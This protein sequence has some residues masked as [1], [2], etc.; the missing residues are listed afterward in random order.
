MD[1]ANQ[2]DLVIRKATASDAETILA[3]IRMIGD[4]LGTP[5]KISATAEDFRRHGFGPSPAFEVLI[6]EIAGAFAGLCLYF[7]SFSTWRGKPGAYIQ[8]LV[9]DKAFRGS[10]VAEALLRQTARHVRDK[11]GVYLRLSVDAS[12]LTAQRFYERIG[13][14]HQ[15]EEHIHAIYG[16]AFD[17]LA[18]LDESGV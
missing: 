4:H 17:A 9:V 2:N 7:R 18:G 13:L 1:A 12:N 14:L 5:H 16:D 3:G 6:A 15:P 8:D 11:G 10:G